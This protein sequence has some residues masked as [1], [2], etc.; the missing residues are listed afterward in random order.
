[1]IETELN[2][3]NQ[4]YP[5]IHVIRPLLDYDEF[6]LEETE[7]GGDHPDRQKAKGIV[8]QCIEYGAIEHAGRDYVDGDLRNRY[9]WHEQARKHFRDYL[10]GL[11]SLP[12][13]CPIHIPDTRDDPDGI[14][15]CKYC[16]RE[17]SDSEF[18]QLVQ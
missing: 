14:I 16:N 12:C 9:R 7:L 3:L 4:L 1:M 11:D 13:N 17:Y 5:K 8:T 15:S 2:D 6:R 10:D 18:K